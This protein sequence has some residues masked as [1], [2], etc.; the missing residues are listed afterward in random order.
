MNTILSRI[1]EEDQKERENWK[2][3]GKSVPLEEVQQRDKERLKMVLEMILKDELI[4]GVDN[5]HA[6]MVL[7]HSDNTEHYKLAHELCS[8]AIKLGEEKAKWLYAATL[9][10]YLIN[11]G[12]KFQ[13]F[14][15][16]YK[17]NEKDLWE[18]FPVD[19]ET[20]DALRAQYNVPILSKL[21][22]RE[23]TLNS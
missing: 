21:K 16:Q 22:E 3:W 10:R 7:Q 11:T 12:S 19:P 2:D 6:A 8:K 18:L 23:K 17:K 20:T 4:E 9:D 15:T 14:G 13:K 1:Y 5:Y